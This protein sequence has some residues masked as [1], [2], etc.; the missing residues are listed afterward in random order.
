MFARTN[1]TK[2][3]IWQWLKKW[4]NVGRCVWN[5]RRQHCGIKHLFHI[6]IMFL[7]YYLSKLQ[8]ISRYVQGLQRYT[9]NIIDDLNYNMCL[10]VTSFKSR[11]FLLDSKKIRQILLNANTEEFFQLLEPG[12]E[13]EN[14][15]DEILATQWQ[16]KSKTS[17]Q[18][19]SMIAS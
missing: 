12:K 14:L 2:L 15:T 10:H 13:T 18:G 4:I 17:P 9:C 11:L 7:I 19:L 1:S 5:S 3:I 8:L 16:L 6:L